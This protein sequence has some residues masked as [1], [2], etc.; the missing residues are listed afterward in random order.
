MNS[1]RSRVSEESVPRL[2]R[3]VLDI[4]TRCNARCLFCSAIQNPNRVQGPD[5]SLER[6]QQAARHLVGAE[7]LCFCSAASEPYLNLQ[8]GHMLE[9]A[10]GSGQVTSF[11][12]NGASLVPGR[13]LDH[14]LEHTDRIFFSFVS[15]RAPVQE[16]WM[17]GTRLELVRRHMVAITGRRKR[18]WVQMT[19][20][21]FRGNVDHLREIVAFAAEI[22]TDDLCFTHM[23]KEGMADLEGQV[24]AEAGAEEKERWIHEY[25]KARDYAAEIGVELSLDASLRS[26]L[27]PGNVFVRVPGT[28]SEEAGGRKTRVCTDPWKF[29]N[30][31]YDGTCSPCCYTANSIGNVFESSENFWQSR[32]LQA[33]RNGLL[34]GDLGGP[35]RDCAMRPMGTTGELQ[36]ALRVEGLT[37]LNE[38]AANA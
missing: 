27:Y 24:I 20:L 29:L 19:A 13:R 36:D 1:T 17:V 38:K 18:P 30:I 10:R 37:V 9:R 34:S 31:F 5:W 22:G 32:K 28:K 26:A 35:C 6:Y 8:L 11:F 2:N 12:S 15:P 23:R 14:V 21:I 3:G 25:E 7:H 16:R 4:G 33:I